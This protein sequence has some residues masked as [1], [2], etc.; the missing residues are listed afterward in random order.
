MKQNLSQVDTKINDGLSRI[1]KAIE[2]ALSRIDAR[3]KELNASLELAKKS[4]VPI[5]VYI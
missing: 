5:G 3:N 1:D 4:L 2:T